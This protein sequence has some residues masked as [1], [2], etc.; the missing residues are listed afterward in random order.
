MLGALA[1]S[2]VVAS[3][4]LPM[5]GRFAHTGLNVLQS[6]LFFAAL[7]LLAIMYRLRPGFQWRGVA[8]AR[9]GVASA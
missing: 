4:Y 6:Y 3:H 1:V 8:S 7:L 2:Y 9:L 5:T